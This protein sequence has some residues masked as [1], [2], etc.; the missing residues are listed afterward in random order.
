[1]GSQYIATVQIVV[2]NDSEISCSE[3][4]RI[5][6]EGRVGNDVATD[7]S[8]H[9]AVISHVSRGH[10]IDRIANTY[11]MIIRDSAFSHVDMNAVANAILDN[12][13]TQSRV[14]CQQ[15]EITKDEMRL[16]K[17]AKLDDLEKLLN[18]NSSESLTDVQK[19]YIELKRRII[20]KICTKEDASVVF[21]PCGH[22][23]A[24]NPCY[25]KIKDRKCPLC[26]T[27]HNGTIKA[28]LT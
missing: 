27:I 5:L 12:T 1:M 13:V 8:N 16:V 17:K 23:S 3:I 4:L 20:C 26:K 24:C 19:Q 21:L 22:L 14:G 11:N 2:E 9:P 28:F 25:S 18:D 7:L 6:K 15:N 10:G